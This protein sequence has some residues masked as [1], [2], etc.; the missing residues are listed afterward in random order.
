MIDNKSL[1]LSPCNF[2]VVNV[3][4]SVSVKFVSGCMYLSKYPKDDHRLLKNLPKWG[5]VGYL[6]LES[7]LIDP[8]LKFCLQ[9]M[10]DMCS[11]AQS[12][13]LLFG[14]QKVTSA[15]TK[16]GHGL[17]KK[18]LIPILYSLFIFYSLLFIFPLFLLQQS[19]FASS[20]LDSNGIDFDSDSKVGVE[21]CFF[22]KN[23]RSFFPNF[24]S[25]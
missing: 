10:A 8:P 12:K 15:H 23:F 14:V 21:N 1:K 18:I 22:K 9:M 16:D 20:R 3:K 7:H 19:Y 13:G 25:F 5:S 6:A 17:I 4:N 11:L 24:G 2:Y